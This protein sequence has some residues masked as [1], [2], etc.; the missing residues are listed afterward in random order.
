MVKIVF[1]V[2]TRKCL[3]FKIVIRVMWDKNE[4]LMR[5]PQVTPKIQHLILN[6]TFFFH[7]QTSTLLFTSMGT[8]VAL[9]LSIYDYSD[10]AD[11]DCVHGDDDNDSKKKKNNNSNCNNRH[12][13]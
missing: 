10:N 3:T 7:C 13:L 8:S 11:K 1:H 2:Q 6:F 9:V 4:S 12:R 5:H